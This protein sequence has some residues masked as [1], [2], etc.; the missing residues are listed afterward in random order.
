MLSGRGGVGVENVRVSVECQVAHRNALVA[1]CQ[2]N[3]V[4]VKR[5]LSHSS[6]IR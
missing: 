4:I 5:A 1:A 2:Q 6:E 3:A